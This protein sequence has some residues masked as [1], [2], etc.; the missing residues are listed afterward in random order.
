MRDETTS[1]A[2]HLADVMGD[3]LH[4][5]VKDPG[6]VAD[7]DVAAGAQSM[8]DRQ[9]GWIAERRCMRRQGRDGDAFW[10]VGADTRRCR[11]VEES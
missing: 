1:A 10:L 3:E 7:A 8:G 11:L 2:R 4:R 5:P 6:E 9:P